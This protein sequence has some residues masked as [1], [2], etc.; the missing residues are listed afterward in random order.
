MAKLLE[1]ELSLWGKY[2]RRISMS[3]GS[4]IF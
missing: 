3:K 2:Q 4:C 1:A